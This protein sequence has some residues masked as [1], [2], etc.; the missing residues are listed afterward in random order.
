MLG[1]VR[2]LTKKLGCTALIVEQNV[3]NALLVSDRVLI[4]RRGRIGYEHNVIEGAD[5]K[6]LLD[7]YSFQGETSEMPTLP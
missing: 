3:K 6:P 2:A 4:L 1:E 5:P 7:A